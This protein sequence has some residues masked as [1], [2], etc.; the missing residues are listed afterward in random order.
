[1]NPKLKKM[2]I[3][4][5]QASG[6]LKLVLVDNVAAYYWRDRATKGYPPGSTASA[7]LT[8]AK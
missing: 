3:V 2:L 8:L 6:G 7:A 4:F 5:P 1:M